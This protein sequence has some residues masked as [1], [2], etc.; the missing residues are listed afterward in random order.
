MIPPVSTP[1]LNGISMKLHLNRNDASAYHSNSQIARVLTETWVAQNMY[2]PRCGNTCLHHLKNNQ[3]VADFDCPICGNQYELKS[4]NGS[5]GRKIPGGSYTSM[6]ERITSNKNPDFLIMNYCKKYMTIK[7]LIFIPKHFFTPDIIEKRKPLSARAHRVGWTGCNI[8]IEKIPEQ[9]RIYIISKGVISNQ[10][11][12]IDTF[13]KI[14]KIKIDNIAGRVWLMDI[15]KC[16]N[17]I[18]DIYFT[19]NDLYA[20]EHDLQLKHPNNQNIKAK[21]RQQLQILRDNNFLS[22]I[23]RGYYKKLI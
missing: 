8:L 23:K 14:K 3:P 10:T 16:I 13:K 4:K 5:L 21:I 2:C 7:N 6:I 9:G 12:I 18:H 19:L 22:F 17:S 11:S 1:L 20:F 15:L